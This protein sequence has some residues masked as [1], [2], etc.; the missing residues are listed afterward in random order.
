MFQRLIRPSKSYSFFLFGARGTGKST[1]LSQH[2]RE[3]AWYLDFLDPEVEDGYAKDPKRL[4]LELLSLKKRPEWVILDE[5]QRV[6]KLLDLVHR[7][8][9]SHRQKFIL[10]GSSARKLK[11]GSANLLAGR[12]FV[13]RLYPLTSIELGPAFDLSETLSWGALPQ[14]SSIQDPADKKAYLRSYCLTYINEEIRMEQVLRK[15]DPFRAFLEIAAQCSGQIINHS[16]IAH[17]VGVDAKTVHGYFE[18]LEDTWLG[19]YLPAFHQSVRKSQKSNPKFYFFDIGVQR[20]L[21]GSLGSIPAESTSYFGSV[22]EA[23]LI[24]EIY[25]LNQYSQMD[26]RLSYFATK[27]QGEI[28]LVLSKN[29]E[30]ALIEIKS[31]KKIS[32]IEIRKLAKLAKDFKGK[33]QV[34]YLSRDAVDL[35][36]EG[37]R[38]MHWKTFLH[39]FFKSNLEPG[40]S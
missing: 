24:L 19:F 1:Y 33:T 15:L 31:S 34:F 6:P 13:N 16:K 23:F 20:A 29:R 22:F 17:E 14:V 3:N 39:D 40:Y 11:R 38:C 10:T 21:A 4:E 9:E 32:E 35:T 8:I 36:I 5:I 18:V 37:V 30:H 7:L 25:R 27:N 26:Y 12:A 28:D 2:F